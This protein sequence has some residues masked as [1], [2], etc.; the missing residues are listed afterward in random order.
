VRMMD[1]QREVVWQR[2]EIEGEGGA[3]GIRPGRPWRGIK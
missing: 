2:S 3:V 1:L